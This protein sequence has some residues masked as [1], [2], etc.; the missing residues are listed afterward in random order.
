M[1]VDEIEKVARL[2]AERAV[3]LILADQAPPFV[4]WLS[5]PQ[6]AAYTGFSAEFL[7]IA[8]HKDD[9]SGPEYIKHARAVRYHRNDLDSWME[10]NRHGRPRAPHATR[11]RKAA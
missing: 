9:G 3:E 5:T 10:R 6:A 2:A 11:R 4:E 8:R 7:E 1:S